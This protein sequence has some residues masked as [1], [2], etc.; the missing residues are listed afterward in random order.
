MDGADGIVPVTTNVVLTEFQRTW[1]RPV[2]RALQRVRAALP[3][4]ERKLPEGDAGLVGLPNQPA[5]PPITRSRLA[6]PELVYLG[7]ALELPVATTSRDD[8]LSRTKPEALLRDGRGG[9]EVGTDA[10]WLKVKQPKYR[11]GERGWEQRKS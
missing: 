8:A 5:V 2:G 1:A 10:K 4:R 7:H 3:C 9:S 6:L 11:D